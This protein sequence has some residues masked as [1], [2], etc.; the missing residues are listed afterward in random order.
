[1]AGTTDEAKSQQALFVCMA[2]NL[3]VL[4]ERKLEREEN[5]RDEKLHDKRLK[6]LKRL[7]QEIRACGRKP[8]PMVLKC[9]RITQRSLQFI[10]WL[11][12]RSCVPDLVERRYSPTTTAY[13][14]V[15]LVNYKHR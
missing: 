5:I 6:R 12:K 1:M 11:Q 13:G 4:L 3:L 9:N 8:N 10:R 15:S 7:E 14:Q 2:H